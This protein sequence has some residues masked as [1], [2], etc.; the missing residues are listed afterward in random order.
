MNE[1]L[2]WFV[3]R[4]GGIVAW[5]LITLSVCWGLFLSTKAAAKA[6]QPKKLLDLHRFL[7][8]LSVVFTAIHVA[9]LVLDN[10]VHFGWYE[11][12]VPWGSEWK[13]TAVAWGVIAMYMLIAVEVTSL[14]M[15]RMPRA[16][17]LQI[18]RLSFGLYI[19]AT[20][21]GLQAGTDTMN[22]WYRMAMLASI[23]IVAFL[24]VILVFAHRK[25]AQ[26]KAAAEAAKVAK[27]SQTVSV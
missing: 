1:Q 8:G 5:A 23:N 19:F 2:Y 7:G 9:G 13:P 20:L 4:S 14:L 27:E 21:H 18:H 16:V 3:A 25:A 24:T 26:A 6:S 15:K 12:L 17:W 10:Y 11:I 22:T